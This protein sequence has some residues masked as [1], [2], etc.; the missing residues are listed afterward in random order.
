LPFFF[1]AI[2]GG[3]FFTDSSGFARGSIALRSLFS[4]KLVDNIKHS[5]CVFLAEIVSELS[6]KIAI[7]TTEAVSDLP[8]LEAVFE[9]DASYFFA[10]H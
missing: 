7:T 3:I 1:T 4:F 6:G 9:Y 10:V 8:K 5:L 2:L